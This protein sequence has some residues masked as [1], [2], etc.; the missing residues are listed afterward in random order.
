MVN[1]KKSN[2][3]Q[4][5]VPQFY[6]RHFANE[7]EQLNVFEVSTQ[8]EY[9]SNIK[10][11]A[12]ERFFYNFNEKLAPAFLENEINEQFV[13]DQ[14]RELNENIAGVMID[15]FQWLRDEFGRLE[16][17]HVHIPAPVLEVFY[18]FILIQLVRTPSFRKKLDPFAEAMVEEFSRQPVNLGL[19]KEGWL[20]F[21][22]NIMSLTALNKC[23]SGDR[24]KFSERFYKG[25]K[26][27]IDIVE[28]T[29][30]NLFKADQLLLVNKS[31][32]V[33]FTSDN[34]VSINWVGGQS[35]DFMFVYLPLNSN[36]ATILFDSRY[37]PQMKEFEG[38]GKITNHNVELLDNLNL[39]VTWHSKSRIYSQ[40]SD[41]N[42]VREFV[43]GKIKCKIEFKF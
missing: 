34:P 28:I 27:Y 36:L 35:N 6:L 9:V 24:I 4:H 41:F 37:C 10:D 1:G 26:R 23:I 30:Q 31:D 38:F 22:H 19:D 42:L 33:F 7:R 14:I 5:Y 12:C 3:K 43:N 20:C 40:E 17:K 11:V 16:I 13:D 21:L 15:W 29:Q 25:F 18:D 32:K 39:L 8:R 2:I